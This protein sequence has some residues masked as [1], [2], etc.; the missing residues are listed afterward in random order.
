M[1]G[2][3]EALQDPHARHAMLVHLPIILGGLGFIPA[4]ALLLNKARNHW[5]RATVCV[6]FALA[7]LGAGLAAAAGEEAEEGVEDRGAGLSAAEENALSRHESLGEAGWIWPL[8]PAGLVALTALPKVPVRLGA[9]ALAVVAGVGVSIWIVAT[10]HGGGQLVY[11][12]GL[13]VPERGLATGVNP[14]APPARHHDD[15]D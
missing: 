13:G 14:G 12:Y 5:L 8:I 10:A 11:D 6:W 9:S 1:N 3:L 4:A 7:S 15:D 2:I